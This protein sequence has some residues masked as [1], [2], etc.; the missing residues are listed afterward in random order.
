MSATIEINGVKATI[1]AG[2]WFCDDTDTL[3]ALKGL[4]QGSYIPDGVN[5]REAIAKLSGK[6]ISEDPD[7]EEGPDKEGY[8]TVF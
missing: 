1:T 3:A 5:A 2:E 8:Q 6:L 7:S 4:Y